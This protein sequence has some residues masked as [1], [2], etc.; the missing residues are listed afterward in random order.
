[1]A[2]SNVPRRTPPSPAAPARATAWSFGAARRRFSTSLAAEARPR[3]MRTRR[4][5]NPGPSC[6][7]RATSSRPRVAA[8]SATATITP[9]SGATTR[10][11]AGI[12]L[13]E[14][15]VLD[16]PLERRRLAGDPRPELLVAH[17]AVRA[18]VPL[19]RELLPLRRLH[20]P[21]E[22]VGQR[23]NALDRHAL[24]GR[25][26]AELRQRDVEAQLLRRRHVSER[27][28]SPFRE[29]DQRPEL[30]GLQVLQHVAGLL[31]EHL[32]VAAERGGV[33]LAWLRVRHR[34]HLVAFLLRSE[35]RRVGKECRSR[36]PPSHY[37]TNRD[38]V[39]LRDLNIP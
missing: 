23:L 6:S 31:V 32:G 7:P 30:A 20:R 39:G 3:P 26:A 21:R 1:M 28:M 36:W 33:T 5:Q 35:E 2:R 12:L 9:A 13:A 8:N 22:R 18:H 25:Q 11:R 38:L 19:L 27:R 14:P 17:E 24:A 34:R 4:G 16:Q 37:I 29:D 15:E 10:A